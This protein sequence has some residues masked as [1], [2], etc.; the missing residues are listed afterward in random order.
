MFMMKTVCIAFIIAAVALLAASSPDDKNKQ[1]SKSAEG[2][3]LYVSP[4]GNDKNP[5]TKDQPVRTLQHA[6]DLVR[7]LNQKMNADITVYLNGGGYPPTQPL[8]LDPA[9]SGVNGH[10]IVYTFAA[11]DRPVSH[12]GVEGTGWE[13]ADEGKK[14]GA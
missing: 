12:R 10:H 13:R 7:R 4:S 9:D 8:A 5:G 1:P 2:I 6:R 14:L 11:G 3:A